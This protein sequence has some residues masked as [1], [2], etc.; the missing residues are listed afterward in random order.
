MIQK[1]LKKLFIVF[2]QFRETATVVYRIICEKI[3]IFCILTENLTVN[4]L[5]RVIQFFC[6]NFVV[7]KA[8][9]Q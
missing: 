3:R 1:Q 7:E 8:Q 5:F 4:R 9:K 2:Q 6:Q